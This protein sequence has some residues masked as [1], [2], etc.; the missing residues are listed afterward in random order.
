VILS[1]DAS[2]GL[3]TRLENAGAD[4][5]ITK[6]LDVEVV[7]GLLDEVTRGRLR[8]DSGSDRGGRA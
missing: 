7:L 5:F 1:A 2:P 6:P 8:Q 3:A 4:R